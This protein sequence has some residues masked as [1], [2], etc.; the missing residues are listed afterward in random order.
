MLTSSGVP[1]AMPSC[2]VLAW[3]IGLAG[4]AFVSIFAQLVVQLAQWGLSFSAPP[5]QL[6]AALS[7]R[8]RALESTPAQLHTFWLAVVGLLRSWLDLQL[9]LVGRVD[10]LPAH[11]P[12][13]RWNRLAASPRSP[14]PTQSA[15]ARR[16]TDYSAGRRVERG[17]HGV[18][19]RVVPGK[20]LRMVRGSAE[21]HRFLAQN[22]YRPACGGASTSTGSAPR[23]SLSLHSTF[24]LILQ[25]RIH[26]IDDSQR[27]IEVTSLIFS[28]SRH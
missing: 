12:R 9:F 13:R 20:S 3:L 15:A 28:N 26:P 8:P 10:H 5:D 23:P 2:L 27:L 19:A 17:R 1:S 16:G 6:E 4:L 24:N 7:G 14:C 11:P 22:P 21:C 25:D 18:R